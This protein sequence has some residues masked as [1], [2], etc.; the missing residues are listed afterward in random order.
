MIDLLETTADP[1]IENS[2]WDCLGLVRDLSARL[3]S[4]V[5]SADRISLLRLEL[6]LSFLCLSHCRCPER[7]RFLVRIH[8]QAQRQLQHHAQNLNQG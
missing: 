4:Q 7:S 2:T 1:T 8:D 5:A 3:S 6:R